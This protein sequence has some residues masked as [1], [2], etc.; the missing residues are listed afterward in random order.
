MC[1]FTSCNAANSKTNNLSIFGVVDSLYEGLIFKIHV[2]TVGKFT[3]TD[4]QTGV[5]K[6]CSTDL[7]HNAGTNQNVIEI[8]VSDIERTVSCLSSHG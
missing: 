5:Q 2:S 7:T 8:V 3:Q 4:G 1:F 6:K